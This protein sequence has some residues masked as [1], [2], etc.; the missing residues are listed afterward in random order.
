MI[1][2]LLKKSLGFFLLLFLFSWVIT[3]CNNNA[4]NNAEVSS[5][6]TVKG[7][8]QES[9]AGFLVN[10]VLLDDVSFDASQYL[11]KTIEVEGIWHDNMCEEAK[12]EYGDMIVQCLDGPYLTNVSLIKVIE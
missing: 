10:G 1:I 5:T 12:K 9:K 11:G 7:L 2:I 6:K 8:V 4:E 3:G